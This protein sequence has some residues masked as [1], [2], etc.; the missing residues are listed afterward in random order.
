MKFIYLAYADPGVCVCGGDSD[1]FFLDPPMFS[2]FFL[3]NVLNKFHV[4][5]V[6]G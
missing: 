4:Y 6:L 5:I 1:E 3:Y 2:N